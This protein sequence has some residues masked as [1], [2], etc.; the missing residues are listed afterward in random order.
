[1]VEGTNGYYGMYDVQPNDT[2][3]SRADFWVY[4]PFRKP[5][6][7]FNVHSVIFYDQFGNKH[8]VKKLRFIYT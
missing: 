5:N 2:R 6:E 1:M 4:P 7:P 3:N 8:V